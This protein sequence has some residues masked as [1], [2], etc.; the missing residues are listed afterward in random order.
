MAV[1][2]DGEKC[3]CNICGNEVVVTKVGGGA[4]KIGRNKKNCEQYRKEGRRDDKKMRRRI[5]WLKNRERWV[6]DK[7]YQSQQ[8]TRRIRL[9][10]PTEAV[11]ENL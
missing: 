6:A 11:S 8:E 2:K 4:R 7:V 10:K 9:L 3:R 1:E 5:K